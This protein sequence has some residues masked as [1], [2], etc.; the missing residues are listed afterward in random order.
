M[1]SITNQLAKLIAGVVC[2]KGEIRQ[3][4]SKADGTP[5]KLMDNSLI[6][7]FGWLPKY[8][9]SQGGVALAYEDFQA[10]LSFDRDGAG[11]AMAK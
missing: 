7:S 8:S 6:R 9:F 5:R 11:K 1:K 2:F 3:D 4:T 10:K